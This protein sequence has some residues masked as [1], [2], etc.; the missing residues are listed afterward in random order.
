MARRDTLSRI[1]L[2]LAS[3][4]PLAGYLGALLLDRL[5][6]NP[7][8]ALT[9][10]LGTWALNFLLLTLA[11]TPLRRLAGWQWLA[12]RRRMLGLFGFF[13][14]L[15]HLTA[16][17]GFDQAFDWSGIGRDI[18][19]RP[20]ITVGML[21]FSVLL[22]LAATSPRAVVRRLGGA[23]WQALHRAVYAAGV[24]AVLHYFWLVK[25]DTRLPWRYA[26]VLAVLLGLRLAWKLRARRLGDS[27]GE[28]SG[29]A[30]ALRNDG[31]MHAG[32]RD[33]M[34]GDRGDLD[35]PRPA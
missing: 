17:L 5:G 9:R 22:M 18:L 27:S 8:E 3:L 7:A 28:S 30:D 14:A 34:R 15:L 32:S 2:F 21:T 4:L 10:A 25:L 11:V 16:Y 6:A 23:R 35:R 33:A 13:Y 20:F 24:L 31:Q 1:A 29:V 12:R 26:A 19:K